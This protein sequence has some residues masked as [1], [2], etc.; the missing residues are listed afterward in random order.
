MTCGQFFIIIFSSM[1]KK[2]NIEKKYFFHLF[3]FLIFSIIKS[4]LGGN[5]LERY[6]CWYSSILVIFSIPKLGL[7]N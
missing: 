7:F 5:N 1:N 4:F 3:V 6:L 2:V